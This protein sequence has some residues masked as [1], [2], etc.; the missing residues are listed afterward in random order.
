MDFLFPELLLYPEVHGW[1][2]AYLQQG[3]WMNNGRL[4]GRV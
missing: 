2:E 4:S 1:F 3:A